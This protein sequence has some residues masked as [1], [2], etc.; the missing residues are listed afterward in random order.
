MKLQSSEFVSFH[1]RKQRRNILLTVL[2]VVALAI[3]EVFIGKVKL[4]CKTNWRDD[5]VSE[6]GGTTVNARIRCEIISSR[7]I[8]RK[9]TRLTVV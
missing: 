5:I 7:N 4:V 9:S 8:G 3:S 6:T 2:Q 1:W